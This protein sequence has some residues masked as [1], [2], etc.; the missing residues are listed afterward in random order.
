MFVITTLLLTISQIMNLQKLHQIQAIRCKIMISDKIT[1][2]RYFIT[3]N[4]IE[5]KLK[6]KRIPFGL[7]KTTMLIFILDTT[8]KIQKIYINLIKNH[9]NTPFHF[10]KKS[11]TKLKIKRTKKSQMSEKTFEMIICNKIRTKQAIKKRSEERL[12]TPPVGLEPTTS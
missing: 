1:H 7:R 2:I 10:N 11:I 4:I 6:M 3:N 8:I 5:Q 9:L 12:N